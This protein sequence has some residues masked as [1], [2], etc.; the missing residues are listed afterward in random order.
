MGKLLQFS[1]RDKNWTIVEAEGSHP[2]PGYGQSICA[3]GNKLYLF[4]GTS[5]HVYVNDLYVFD[6]ATKMWKKEETNGRRPSPRYKHQVAAIGN[7]MYVIGGGLYDPP[8]GPIDTYYLDVD[9]MTWHDVECKGSMPNSRIAH[10]IVQLSRD[11]NRLVMFGGRDDSGRR[12]NELSELDV[13]T[14]E[15][16]VREEECGQPDARD[17]HTAVMHEDQMFIF[18]GSNGVE[19]NNDVFR[20]T[21]V[22]QPPSLMIL[23][24]Q[25]LRTNLNVVTPEQLQSLPFELQIGINH[26]NP[27]VRSSYN[28]TWYMQMDEKIDTARAPVM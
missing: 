13:T 25:T 27:H 16:S 5:G 7:R 20:F 22:H 12:R 24:L 1:I 11:S 2:P 28:T 10:T 17:F 26:I 14:G 15:W 4:G 23:A 8:K 18:G 6:E 3:I 19:R 9:T 21:V